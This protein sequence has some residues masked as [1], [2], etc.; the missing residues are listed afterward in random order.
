ME[1]R[2]NQCLVCKRNATRAIVSRQGSINKGPRVGH[3][4][5]HLRRCTVEA[6]GQY[7]PPANPRPRGSKSNSPGA[8]L[9]AGAWLGA[10]SPR[11]ELSLR[12]QRRRSVTQA[13]ETDALPSG[14]LDLR[15]I[16]LTSTWPRSES[17]APV[18]LSIFEMLEPGHLL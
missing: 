17:G 12:D 9:A 13:L 3:G 6:R 14:V 1:E 15:V 16:L 10:G 4:E 18:G 11:A 7:R 5:G 8:Q 2:V